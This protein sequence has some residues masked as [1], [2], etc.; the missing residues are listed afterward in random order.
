MP[1]RFFNVTFGFYSSL[2][3]LLPRVLTVFLH[4]ELALPEGL[5]GVWER[6]DLG[7]LFWVI[8]SLSSNKN[9]LL[10][11]WK[12]EASLGQDKHFNPVIHGEEA[13]IYSPKWMKAAQGEPSHF[14]SL[15]I[16]WR[17]INVFIY[18]KSIVGHHRPVSMRSFLVHHP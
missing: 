5:C 17:V 13:Q 16:P 10:T 1:S 3:F 7:S 11:R 9:T 6:P 2:H 18:F 12:T 15:C 4:Q 14:T 8:P